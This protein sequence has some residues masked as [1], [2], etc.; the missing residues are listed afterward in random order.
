MLHHNRDYIAVA[1][2]VLLSFVLMGLPQAQKELIASWCRG[3]LWVS[4]Q[5][6]FSSIIEHGRSQEKTR[7]LL[8]QNVELAL[9]NM[10]LQEAKQENRRLRRALLFKER[11]D[12][13]P[14]IPA[15]VIARDADQIFDTI[16]IDAGEDQGI[17]LDWPVV[18]TEGLVGHIIQVDAHSSIVQLIMRSRVS[19]VV[20][21]E[22]VRA[23]GVVLWVEGSKFRLRYVDA[24]SE[25]AKGDLVVSSG[26]GGLFPKGIT[27]GKVIEVR[28]QE[29]D[30]L[31]KQV[32]L[33][34]SV[35]FLDLEEAFVIVS[36]DQKP[37][38]AVRGAH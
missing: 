15:E 14:I 27:I 4:G 18:T 26:L 6:L 32:F 16:T 30:P 20:Q 35:D 11:E 34:S 3:S 13:Q 21:V 22:G 12:A 37:A 25:I 10:R 31:F 28:E 24:S 5:W 17:Q 2:A 29:Q 7:Y 36:E 38:V 9:E 19:A 33:E 1:L 23:Q 8:R